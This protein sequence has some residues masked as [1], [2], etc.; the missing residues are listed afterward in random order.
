MTLSLAERTQQLLA[1]ERLLVKAEADIDEGA[2]RIRDQEDRVR[3]LQAG[4][5][6]AAH[7]QKLVELLKQTLVEWERHRTLII[8]RVDFLKREVR[9]MPPAAH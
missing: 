5:H 3:E 1:E 8:Q 7:A 4:G 9:S 2:R 6:D